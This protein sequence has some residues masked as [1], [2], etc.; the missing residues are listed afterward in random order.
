MKYHCVY[1]LSRK[2]DEHYLYKQ[3]TNIYSIV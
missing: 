2:K 1:L 3:S